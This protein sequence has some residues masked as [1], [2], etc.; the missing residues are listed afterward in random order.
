MNYATI[1]AVTDV[2]E[3]VLIILI[4]E[5]IKLSINLVIS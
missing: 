1:T 2:S 5:E 3:S 4:A